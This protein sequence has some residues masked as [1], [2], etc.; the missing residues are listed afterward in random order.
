MNAFKVKSYDDILPVSIK[1]SW[2]SINLL[3]FLT[4]L[5]GRLILRIIYNF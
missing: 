1:P 3:T 5:A 4:F 2:K